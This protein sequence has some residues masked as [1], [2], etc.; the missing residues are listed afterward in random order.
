MNEAYSSK[1][2]PPQHVRSCHICYRA[3]KNRPWK[4]IPH[5]PKRSSCQN[6]RCFLFLCPYY[7]T[8][9]PSYFSNKIL[10]PKPVYPKLM[11]RILP[12]SICSNLRQ[13]KTKYDKNVDTSQMCIVAV[14]NNPCLVDENYVSDTIGWTIC[15]DVS[16]MNK[17]WCSHFT[18]NSNKFKY[19]VNVHECYNL[20]W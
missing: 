14:Y 9:S 15:S 1:P 16:R 10:T 13:C 12:N 20:V 7:I 18:V 4:V 11:A 2:T 17:N 8:S 19:T 3:P 5:S 6:S